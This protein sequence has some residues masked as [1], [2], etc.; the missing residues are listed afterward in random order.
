[1]SL[2][3][4]T[5][6]HTLALGDGGVSGNGEEASERKEKRALRFETWIV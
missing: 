2:G 3:T 6:V 4:D 5:F 1:M